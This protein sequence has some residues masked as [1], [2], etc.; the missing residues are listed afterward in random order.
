[1]PEEQQRKVQNILK[2]EF[3]N[4]QSFYTIL[5]L[6]YNNQLHSATVN[7]NVCNFDILKDIVLL[8]QSPNTEIIV[9]GS[10]HSNYHLSNVVRNGYTHQPV[11]VRDTYIRL[12]I[13]NSQNI[14]HILTSPPIVMEQVPIYLAQYPSCDVPVFFIFP[15][16]DMNQMDND[17]ENLM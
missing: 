1:M 7:E 17:H 4:P 5:Q 10:V 16:Y 11:F 8:A 3:L 15:N 12:R 9:Q 2:H 14:V 6:L 13:G